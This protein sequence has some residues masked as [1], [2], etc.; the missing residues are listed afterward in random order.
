MKKVN[1]KIYE[2]RSLRLKLYIEREICI[3]IEKKNTIET[4]LIVDS[5][6]K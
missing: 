6:T 1:V 5:N 4:P 2:I 3:T